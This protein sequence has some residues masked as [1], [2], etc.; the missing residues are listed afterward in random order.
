MER[1]SVIPSDDENPLILVCPHGYEKDDENTAE[2]TEK[3][4]SIL[5]C[6]AIIN[7][8]FERSNTVDYFKDK[9]DCNNVEHIH[10]DVV[11]EEFLDPINRTVREVLENGYD[12]Q[13]FLIHGMKNQKIQDTLGLSVDIVLGYGEA[14]KSPSYSCD[15][16]R[17]N[18]F[19]YCLH[20]SKL[21]SFTGKAGGK[22]AAARR[23]NLN[24]YYRQWEYDENVHSMQVEIVKALRETEMLDTTAESLC[25]ALTEYLDFLEAD[26]N[27]E[28]PDYFAVNW[29][30][31]AAARPS[32]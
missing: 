19:L 28:I 9:A 11:K 27:D 13:I 3:M 14:P 18:G 30:K 2:L 5:G 4:A 20:R 17:K 26:D 25:T 16:W 6:H 1:V 31:V 21:V 29:E 10:E 12:P 7:R 15:E 8:G 24:Q 32:L 22:Y 23:S